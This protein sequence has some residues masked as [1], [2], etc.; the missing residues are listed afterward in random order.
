MPRQV[1]STAALLTAAALSAC[2]DS[3]GPTTDA[4]VNF[5]VAT[6]PAST[7]AAG[8][9]AAI[10]TPETFTDGTNT[11]VRSSASAGCSRSRPQD[12]PS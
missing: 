12:V 3:G 8:A 6:R 11:L 2:S 10:G 7:A 4:Q 5:N 9:M 1:I